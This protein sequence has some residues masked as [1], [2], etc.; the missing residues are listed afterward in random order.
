MSSIFAKPPVESKVHRVHSPR[1]GNPFEVKIDPRMEKLKGTLRLERLASM[2]KA[3]TG[4]DLP[5]KDITAEL[6]YQEFLAGIE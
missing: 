5:L 1:Y 4:S 3:R 6:S 2:V